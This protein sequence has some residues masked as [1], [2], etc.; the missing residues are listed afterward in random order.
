M[1]DHCVL[2]LLLMTLTPSTLFFLNCFLT[3]VFQEVQK[4]YNDTHVNTKSQC[5]R[6]PWA[7]RI[8]AIAARFFSPFLSNLWILY[9]LRVIVNLRSF[10]KWDNAYGGFYTDLDLSVCWKEREIWWFSRV[11][12]FCWRN[13]IYVGRNEEVSP[14]QAICRESNV[15][16][17]RC[18]WLLALPVKGHLYRFLVS[19]SVDPPQLWKL[20][21]VEH[22]LL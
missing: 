11:N 16:H 5:E 10:N 21:A 2:L 14:F 7:E 22:I 17:F 12:I 1:D 4:N 9:V 3:V 19:L 15:F 18:R 20:Q 13:E 6:S 8:K